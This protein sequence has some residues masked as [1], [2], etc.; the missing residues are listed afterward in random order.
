M[1]KYVF[2]IAVLINTMFAC[3][4]AF[5]GIIEN[6]HEGWYYESIWMNIG[7]MLA[8]Y[9]LFTFVFTAL[10]LV[11]TK[12]NKTGAL[13]FI[14]AGILIPLLK[15]RTNAAIFIFAI[16]LA[17]TGILF[18]FGDIKNKKWAFMI[19][20][21][22][23]LITILI[24]GFEPAIRIS[25]RIDDGNFGIRTVEGNKTKLQWAPEGPGWATSTKELEGK[26]WYD[27][28]EIVSKLKEDG[29]TLSDTPVYI[30]RLPTIE[31]AI[32]SLTRNGN[33]SGGTWN[34][35]TSEANYEIM[36]DKESPLWK[37]HSP[38][39]YWWT[40]TELND[41]TAYR[42]VYNGSFQKIKKKVK[43]GSLGYRA[44]KSIY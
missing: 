16:P 6:F 38:I 42:I 7:L 2:W 21:G 15:I 37:I 23:P 27:I 31:E 35:S 4:W 1:T 18:W 39:I 41:T 13:L 5:W 22:A 25:K 29:K 34:P 8:Q 17:L 30:W 12:W 40:S 43:M 28:T 26:N 36:P 10:G 44:V 24:F 19:I 3:L 32:C 14:I 9:L 33:N 11:A 20:A